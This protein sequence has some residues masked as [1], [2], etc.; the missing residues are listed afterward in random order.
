MIYYICMH[1]RATCLHR[2]MDI[3]IGANG[4]G[5]TKLCLQQVVVGDHI[6]KGFLQVG[7]VV[8]RDWLL[9]TPAVAR[10]E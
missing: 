10:C 5:T 7:E 3:D 8:A 9:A 4:E 2:R 1:V 6:E